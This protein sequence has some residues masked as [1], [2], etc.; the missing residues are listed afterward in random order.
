MEVENE[1]NKQK[2]KK[3]PAKKEDAEKKVTNKKT[4]DEE[5]TKKETKKTAAK[6]VSSKKDVVKEEPVKEEP[7]KE[8]IPIIR[9]EINEDP[10]YISAEKSEKKSNLKREIKSFFILLLI[11]GLIVG[12]TWYWYNY[13]YDKNRNKEEEQP[14]STNTELTNDISYDIKS[15]KSSTNLALINNKYIIEYNNKYIYKV[16]DTNL[17]VIFE[18]EQYYSDFYY[19]NDNKL[20]VIN[21]DTAEYE[22]IID[23]YILSEDKFI[24][25]DTLNDSAVHYKPIIT[26]DEILLGF[27]GYYDNSL[28]EDAQDEELNNYLYLLGHDKKE[29]GKMVIDENN[30]IDNARYIKNTSSNYLIVSLDDKIGVYDIQNNGYLINPQYTKVIPGFNNEFIVTN[31]DDLT[32]IINKDENVIEM[33][34]DFISKGTDY[35]VLG[36]SKKVS[37]MNKKHDEV[38]SLELNYRHL[39]EDSEILDDGAYDFFNAYDVHGKI[40]LE[41]LSVFLTG[42]NQTNNIY[43]FDENNDYE[44]IATDYFSYDKE[45]NLIYSYNS[46]NKKLTIYKDDLEVAYDIDLAIYNYKNIPFV[47]VYN[48]DLLFINIGKGLYFDRYTGESQGEK[49]EVVYEDKKFKTTYNSKEKKLIVKIADKSEEFK[50]YSFDQN[51]NLIKKEDGTYLIFYDNLAIT[52]IPTKQNTNE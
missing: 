1:K 21:E 22:N 41:H 52:I 42:R 8:V 43:I 50:T 9:N 33:T 13:V 4:K 34:Y 23:I 6:K 29:I 47:S 16:L 39:K 15:Y 31:E 27:I 14:T 28:D 2:T 5:S 7:K 12:A 48:N 3:A 25:K 51:A 32:G 19:G 38:A 18:G 40:I 17:D 20:Y 26:N 36:K 30:I 24:K 46:N 49:H 11:I 35:Y 10:N 45:D 44:T 37:I